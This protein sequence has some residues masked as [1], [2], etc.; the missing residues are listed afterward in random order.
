VKVVVVSATVPAPGTAVQQWICAAVL[1]VAGPELTIT[2][3]C[4]RWGQE[5]IGSR[6]RW[7]RWAALLE[8]TKA[9]LEETGAAWRCWPSKDESGKCGRD[10]EHSRAPWL[11]SRNR[12]LFG[13]WLKR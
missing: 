6:W 3:R 13:V 5:Y 7:R 10:P 2:C 4:A 8:T 12:P 11:G 9:G 1:A